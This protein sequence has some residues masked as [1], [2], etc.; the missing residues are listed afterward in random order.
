MRDSTGIGGMSVTL[1]AF[2]CDS[3]QQS[4]SCVMI[5]FQ[6]NYVPGDGSKRIPEMASY[7]IIETGNNPVN[8]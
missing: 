6:H 7:A 2:V 4:M 1:P 5:L 8:S 3:Q